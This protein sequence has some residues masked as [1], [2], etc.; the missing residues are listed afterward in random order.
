MLMPEMKP[1]PVVM[2][3]LATMRMPKDN[4]FARSNVQINGYMICKKCSS[5]KIQHKSFIKIQEATI[6]AFSA[7][8]TPS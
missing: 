5:S 2:H 1:N 8:S 6:V 4:L 3:S 7:I